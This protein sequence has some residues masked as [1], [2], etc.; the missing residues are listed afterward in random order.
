MHTNSVFLYKKKDVFVAH[1]EDAR[2]AQEEEFASCARDKDRKRVGL[3]PCTNANDRRLVACIPRRQR[4][5]C[6]HT[7]HI[8]DTMDCK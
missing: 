6:M 7:Y 1:G 8:D 2:F 5:R 4:P 3:D